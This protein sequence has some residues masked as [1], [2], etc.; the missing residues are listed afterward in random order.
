[1]MFVTFVFAA[2]LP[3]QWRGSPVILPENCGSFTRLVAITIIF[4]YLFIAGEFLY[5][6][7]MPRVGLRVLKFI[8]H[9]TTFSGIHTITLIASESFICFSP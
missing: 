5:D 4:Y 6:S 8:F 1:M 3:W 7:D 2:F 9:P